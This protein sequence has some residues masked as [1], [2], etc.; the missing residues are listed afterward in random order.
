MP[1]SDKEVNLLEELAAQDEP[2]S[3]AISAYLE[4][5]EAVE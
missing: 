3:D 1:L 2:W 5:M 4:A